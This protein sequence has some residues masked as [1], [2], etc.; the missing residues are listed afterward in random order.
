MDPVTDFHVHAFPGDLAPRAVEKLQALH[1]GRAALDGTVGALLASM[2]RAGIARS[3][4]CSIATAPKQVEPIL[5]WSLG[6]RSERIEPFASVHPASED[7]PAQVERVAR[8][9]LL[10]IKLHPQ[11]QDFLPDEP[12][13]WPIYDAVQR[14]GLILVMHC[15]LDLCYPPDD[16]RAHPERVVAVI[17]RFPAV[18][19]VATHMG[20]WR[21]WEAA[22]DLLAGK[23]LHLETSYS[24]GV[25]PGGL[26]RQIVARHPAERIMFG[27]DSPWRNQLEDLART[28]ALFTDADLRRLVLGANATR[29]LDQTRQRIARSLSPSAG[30]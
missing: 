14:V 17:E 23:A 26:L 10:G 24:V 12:R 28:R 9:G 7:A 1:G 15:G 21:R 5:N 22:L 2:D 27:T 18:T 6:I 13:M 11:Y 19:L 8:S 16:E 29:L 25:A 30:F 20:G 3:V 4:V